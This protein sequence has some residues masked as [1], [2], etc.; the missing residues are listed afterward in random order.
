[1]VPFQPSPDWYEKYWYSQVPATSL[2]VTSIFASL[3]ALALGVWR[4]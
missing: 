3:A 4:G 2:S 1:M